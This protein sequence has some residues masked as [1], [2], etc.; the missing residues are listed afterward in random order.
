MGALILTMPA[1]RFQLAHVPLAVEAAREL[2][3]QN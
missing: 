3:L 2:S 1:N